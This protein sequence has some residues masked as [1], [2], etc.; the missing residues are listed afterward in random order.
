MLGSL[1]ST[2]MMPMLGLLFGNTQT[3][4]THVENNS[5]AQILSNSL[6]YINIKWFILNNNTTAHPR[7]PTIVVCI[8]WHML[9]GRVVA[10]LGFFPEADDLLQIDCMTYIPMLYCID[11]SNYNFLRQRCL[12]AQL[13]HVKQPQST[14]WNNARATRADID[15]IMRKHKST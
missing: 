6:I 7:R 8:G 14:L 12:H 10:V 3:W 9:V 1:S 11:W 4:C 5:D 2:N 15:M 13:K